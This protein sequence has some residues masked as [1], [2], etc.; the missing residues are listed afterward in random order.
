MLTK[1]LLYN[2]KTFALH[3]NNFDSVQCNAHCTE[4]S[5]QSYKTVQSFTVKIAYI[6]IDVLASSTREV[7]MHTDCSSI[8]IYTLFIYDQRLHE[9]AGL[10]V[11]TRWDLHFQS[12]V[13]GSGP[14]HLYTQPWETGMLS[15]FVTGCRSAAAD[16]S[17]HSGHQ[18]DP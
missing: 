11:K 16:H 2:L 18:S 14:N 5:Y 6:H 8:Y 10:P 12:A 15:D 13:Q 4:M 17:L 3:C 7:P 1:C 9:F